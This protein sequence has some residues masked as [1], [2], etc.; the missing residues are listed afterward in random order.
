M[1]LVIIFLSVL[2]INQTGIAQ[3]LQISSDRAQT[4]QLREVI[5][6][7]FPPLSVIPGGAGFGPDHLRSDPDDVQSMIRLSNQGQILS[8]QTYY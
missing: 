5:S 6:S 2:I 8:R 7:D 4:A 1:R 3:S